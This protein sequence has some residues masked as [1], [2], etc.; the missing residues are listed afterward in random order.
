MTMY[1]LFR[2]AERPAI[3][4]DNIAQFQNVKTGNAPVT[5]QKL[6]IFSERTLC[7]IRGTSFHHLHWKTR[8][9]T[10][11]EQNTPV[12][13]SWKTS[14][15]QTMNLWRIFGSK[16]AHGNA[17]S[18]EWHENKSRLS[19]ELLIIHS[20]AEIVYLRIILCKFRSA[21]R[22]LYRGTKCHV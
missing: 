8:C 11:T 19:G 9:S 13:T 1:K 16:L 14:V 10:H 3:K 17:E 7:N 12:F 15:P 18:T 5:T 20:S 22:P 6:A 21:R 2:I 4:S